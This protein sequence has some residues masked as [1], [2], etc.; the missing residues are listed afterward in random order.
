MSEMP[1]EIFD[2]IDSRVSLKQL[3][4]SSKDW[5]KIAKTVIMGVDPDKKSELWQQYWSWLDEQESARRIKTFDL[6]VQEFCGRPYSTQAPSPATQPASVARQ[7]KPQTRC[8]CEVIA[9]M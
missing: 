4:T 1:K 3:R 7:P 8:A 2:D 5:E 9:L 6:Q